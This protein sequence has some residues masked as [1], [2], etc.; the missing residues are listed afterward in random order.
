MKVNKIQKKKGKEAYRKEELVRC[1]QELAK[2]GPTSE[3]YETI[4]KRIKAL[5]GSKKESKWDPNQILKIA[6]VGGL[7]VV[8]TL[9]ELPGNLVNVRAIKAIQPAVNLLKL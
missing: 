2:V 9:V 1:Y 5:E 3:D 6:V 4:Q 8:T 7:V